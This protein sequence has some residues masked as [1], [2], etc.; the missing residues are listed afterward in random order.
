MVHSFPIQFTIICCFLIIV[1]TD[2]IYPLIST[3]T[4]QY[5][6][7][8]TVSQNDTTHSLHC[9]TQHCHII[10]DKTY[11]EGQP[12]SCY[13][14]TINA[15]SVLS[16]DIQCIGQQSCQYL[17]VNGPSKS[18][19]LNINC[20]LT[21]SCRYC[22]IN[23]PSTNVSINIDCVAPGACR[24]SYINA[25]NTRGIIHLQCKN[26]YITNGAC[27]ANIFDFSK[28]SF[29]N[30]QCDGW[31]CAMIAKFYLDQ[32]ETATFDFYGM[33]AITYN[34]LSFT[35]N[36]KNALNLTCKGAQT[37]I[38]VDNIACPRTAPCNIKC[39]GGDG[40]R[41]GCGSDTGTSGTNF[42][43]PDDEYQHFNLWCDDNKESCN[44]ITV[45]CLDSGFISK[46]KWIV[47][48]S[49][50]HWT[51]DTFGC[52]PKYDGTIIC[53]ASSDYFI[54]CNSINCKN[55]IIDC[56]MANTVTL[57]CRGT[58]SCI[59][60]KLL[61]PIGNYTSCSVDCN[62][63]SACMYFKIESGVSKI[64]NYLS[65]NCNGISTC[66]YIALLL[67]SLSVTS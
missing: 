8:I 35:E 5:F 4:H 63:D 12:H 2:I 52:C 60:S 43:I 44:G 30:V 10:C 28:S 14:L 32:A 53:P 54:D 6:S 50:N 29:V 27:Y 40:N 56:R 41:G 55:H 37:C 47:D 20:N 64:M 23:I 33:M 11:I 48:E 3:S 19:H 18:A 17:Q 21:E 65:L 67:E 57:D 22:T 26:L 39:F 7:N 1:S 59:G 46:V 36:M 42:V 13:N 9:T 49:Q 16:L 38:Y 58:N 24:D 61:C 34:E 25:S 51:C 31:F 66:S 62:G 15:S 45:E